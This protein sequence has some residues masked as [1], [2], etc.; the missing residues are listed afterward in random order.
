MLGDY[1][2]VIRPCSVLG[3]LLP[4]ADLIILKVPGVRECVYSAA[5]S[6]MK[7]TIR[8]G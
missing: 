4:Q 3:T 5:A 6:S 2:R 8:Q 7:T 1:T